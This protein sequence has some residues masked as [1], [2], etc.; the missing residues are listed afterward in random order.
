MTIHQRGYGVPQDSSKAHNYMLKLLQHSENTSFADHVGSG[1]LMSYFNDGYFQTDPLDS[2]KEMRYALQ[3]FG[4]HVDS[5]AFKTRLQKALACLDSKSVTRFFRLCTSAYETHQAIKESNRN[6]TILRHPEEGDALAELRGSWVN[7]LLTDSVPAF[8]RLQELGAMPPELHVW[9]DNMDAMLMLMMGRMGIEDVRDKVTTGLVERHAALKKLASICAEHGLT[10]I[11]AHLIEKHKF[12]INTPLDSGR[13]ALQEVL[14]QGRVHRAIALLEC[15][16]DLSLAGTKDFVRH[17]CGDGHHG[18]IDFWRQLRQVDEAVMDAQILELAIRPHYSSISKLFGPDGN[19]D[20]NVNSYEMHGEPALAASPIYFSLVENCYL[21]FLALL[22]YGVDPSRPCMGSLN[23]LQAAVVLIRPLF[24]AVLLEEAWFNQ[25]KVVG[26]RNSSLYHLASLGDNCFSDKMWVY[27]DANEIKDDPSAATQD[28]ANHQ[29]LILELL[30]QNTQIDIEHRDEFGL[31]PFLHA[32]LQANL[33]CVQWFDAKSVDKTARA[34]DGCTA[35]HLA[36]ASG[37]LD[38]V[39]TILKMLPDLLEVADNAGRRP[40]H[41]ACCQDQ[42]EM[43]QLLL[44]QQ[45]DISVLDANQWNVLHVSLDCGKTDNF[46]ALVK[47]ILDNFNSTKLQRMLNAKD[48]LGRTCFDILPFLGR[49]DWQRVQEQHDFQFWRYMDMDAILSPQAQSHA[50]AR[51]PSAPWPTVHLAILGLSEFPPAYINPA[52][53]NTRGPY[54]LTPLHLAALIQHDI[55]TR[56]LQRQGADPS[57][58]AHNGQTVADFYNVDP[59]AAPSSESLLTAM[60]FPTQLYYLEQ[61]HARLPITPILQPEISHCVVAKT[62]LTEFLDPASTTHRLESITV[63]QFRQSGAES[64]KVLAPFDVP[65]PSG[66]SSSSSKS[67]R[68]SKL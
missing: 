40:L 1:Y 44:K 10:K 27:G 64:L 6:D 4:R 33:T 3:L 58:P 32:V 41:Y 68:T 36:I 31:T 50:S 66:S 14:E 34:A 21:S 56:A 11:L 18:A 48:E 43:L 22:K 25:C 15:G 35:L 47:F 65:A 60:I 38:M 51:H 9:N 52:L 49:P 54:G 42:P 29:R 55:L 61:S 19:M 57:L 67:H 2:E 37:S 24:V 30:H 53:L 59:A 16:A 62:Y 45:P 7:V 23:A 39:E 28:Q 63:E 13:N 20:L 5:L 8:E 17:I 26:E 46:L 12:D